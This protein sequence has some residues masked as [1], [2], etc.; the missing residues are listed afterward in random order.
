MKRVLAAL[1]AILTVATAASAQSGSTL[2][3]E[4]AIGIAIANNLTL[5]NAAMQ[6]EKAEHDVAIARTRRM[7][8]F[9]IESQASQLLTPVD[10]SFPRG[11]FGDYPGI[12]RFR[13][14]TPR[15]RR[16]AA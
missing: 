3:L 9:S 16:R 7:P 12:G 6:V 14:P 5:Q 1:V 4:E 15:S 10:I 13:R 11:A 8:S 2:S